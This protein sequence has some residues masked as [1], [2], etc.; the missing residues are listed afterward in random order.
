MSHHELALEYRLNADVQAKCLSNM[1]MTKVMDNIEIRCAELPLP[2][3]IDVATG[4]VTMTG[5]MVIRKSLMF[6][7]MTS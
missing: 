5:R 4:P 1:A 3:K 6:R 7:F 2:K